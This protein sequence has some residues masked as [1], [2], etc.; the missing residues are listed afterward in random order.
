[1][2][3]LS[4]NIIRTQSRK[5]LLK[6]EF[7]KEVFFKEL[8]GKF[9]DEVEIIYRDKNIVCLIPKS[10]MTS[11]IYGNKANWCQKEKNGFEGW[12]KAGL[13][14]RFLFKEGGRKIRFTYFTGQ[15]ESR[16]FYWANE[17]GHHILSE[18]GKGKNPFE[19]SSKNKTLWPNEIDTL[20][21]INQIPEECKQ[22]VLEFIEKHK[23]AYEYC[24]KDTE[25]KPVGL[26]AKMDEFES[27]YNY[28]IDAFHAIHE[29]NQNIIISI[30]FDKST[31]EFTINHSNEYGIKINYLVQNERFKDSKSFEKRIKELIVMYR[32]QFN[33]FSSPEK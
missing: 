17:S 29:H 22:K 32:K 21:L 1:M 27:I 2:N 7:L 11:Y 31:K 25:Y 14:I 18:E 33:I 10:Q 24:Y 13:L 6:E 30:H 4:E 19:A 9:K 28:Y 15:N 16:G 23:E 8:T 20:N 5:I 3:S 26:K 12:S